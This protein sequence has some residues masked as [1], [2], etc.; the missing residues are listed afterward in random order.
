MTPAIIDVQ[1]TDDI[2]DVV[3][4]AVQALAEGKLVAFPTETTY[5][6]AASALSPSAVEKLVGSVATS[7]PP[8]LEL[9]VRGHDEVRDYIP[10]LPGM[11][12]RLSRR[13]WPGPVTLVIDDQHPDSLVTQLPE[14]VQKAIAENGAVAFRVPAHRLIHDV[15]RISAGPLVMIRPQSDVPHCTSADDVMEHYSESV[16]LI[17]DDGRSRFGQPAT[18]VRVE[19]DRAKV[20]ESG[21]V[22]D[23]NLKRLSSMIVLFVCTGNTCR[24]PMAEA[25]CRDLVAKRLGCEPAALEDRGV[26]IASAGIAAMMGG[27][28][29]PEAV[30]VLKERDVQLVDHE[31]QPLSDQLVRQADAI[32]TMT[33]HH[34]EAVIA[35]WP[36]TVDR[37]QLLMPD[38]T[39]VSDPIGGTADRY[40]SCAD[41]IEA[42][43]EEWV[44]QLDLEAL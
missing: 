7:G 33:A 22:S 1:S 41:Q 39:D 4:R 29:S 18:V 30:Q 5:S 16:E 27:G 15:L 8:R 17:L 32:M 20:V 36:D 3:H 11:A 34:R 38:G 12:R 14:T 43:L 31:A 9:A 35:Q 25:I 26:I 37:I 19:K 44:A 6:I 42:A 24:S 40:R 23:S 21:V 2:R 28:P 13:C 10:D